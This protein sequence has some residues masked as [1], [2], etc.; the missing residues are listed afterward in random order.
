MIYKN[1]SKK[2]VKKSIVIFL[3]A[4]LGLM[5]AGSRMSF[6]MISRY[7]HATIH[8]SSVGLADKEIS[9]SEADASFIGNKEYQ[10]LGKDLDIVGDINGD[11]FDDIAIGLFF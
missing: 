10:N 5:A 7:T 3:F 2:R 4:V 9:L 1:L 8:T 6:S 11:G